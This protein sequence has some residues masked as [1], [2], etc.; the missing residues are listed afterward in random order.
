MIDRLFGRRPDAD[1]VADLW[2][3]DLECQTANETAWALG[4]P[5]VFTRAGWRAA[6]LNSD[7]VRLRHRLRRRAGLL[8]ETELDLLMEMHAAD[9]EDVTAA[10]ALRV[11]DS[12]VHRLDGETLQPG[13]ELPAVGWWAER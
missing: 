12:D 13:V 9:G 10:A 3:T 7:L 4:R 5:P 2:Q 8:S 11:F 1:L 6:D